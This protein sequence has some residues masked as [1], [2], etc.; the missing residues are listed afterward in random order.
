VGIYFRPYLTEF[1]ETLSKYYTLVVFTASTQEYADAVVAQIDP[2]EKWI[3]LKLYRQHCTPVDGMKLN[4]KNI[5]L[6]LK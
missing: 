4:L 1:L 5:Y 6:I 3:S 2:E